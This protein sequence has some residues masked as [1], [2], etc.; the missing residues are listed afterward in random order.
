M[1]VFVFVIGNVNVNVNGIGTETESVVLSVWC[2]LVF[3]IGVTLNM[4]YLGR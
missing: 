3:S 4:G 1:F 2:D